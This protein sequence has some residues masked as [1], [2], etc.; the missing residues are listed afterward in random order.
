[1][2]RSVPTQM[3]GVDHESIQLLS[4]A[5]SSSVI[6]TTFGRVVKPYG[7]PGLV[8]A[9]GSRSHGPEMTIIPG[10]FAVVASTEPAPVAAT[11]TGVQVA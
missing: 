11:T 8:P 6:I 3:K 9:L 5:W 10:Y 4:W 7:L 1:M 2:R